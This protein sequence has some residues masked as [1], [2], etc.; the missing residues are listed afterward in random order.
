M[1]EFHK[2]WLLCL[3]LVN[4]MVYTASASSRPKSAQS[5]IDSLVSKAGSV[6]CSNLSDNAI[7]SLSLSTSASRQEIYIRQNL[8]SQ[9]RTV[10][11]RE[12]DSS[13]NQSRLNISVRDL[14]CRYEYCKTS[15]DSLIRHISLDLIFTIYTQSGK[16]ISND[17]VVYN[18]T[19]TLA[20]SDIVSLSL[21][22]PDWANSPV[23]ERKKTFFEEVA[24]PLAV[25]AAVVVSVV[26]LFTVRSN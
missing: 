4:C 19:D 8:Y 21:R 24:E 6:I 23:P 14:G 20:F 17:P 13:L 22:L 26:L 9:C 2:I 16:V 3:V 10:S 1:R 15:N 5:V 25:L 18:V 11:F 7:T 12:S